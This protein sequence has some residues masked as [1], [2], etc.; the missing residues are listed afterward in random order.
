MGKQV[1]QIVVDDGGNIVEFFDGAFFRHG[2]LG[3]VDFRQ[4]MSA[5]GLDIPHPRLVLDLHFVQTRGVVCGGRIRGQRCFG[6]CPGA[7]KCQQDADAER[8]EAKC[9][10]GTLVQIGRH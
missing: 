2:D 10:R 5:F 7:G 4:K 6:Q 3:A 1:A 8:I 9:G